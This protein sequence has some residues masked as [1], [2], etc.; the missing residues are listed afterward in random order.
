MDDNTSRPKVSV[1]VITYN[2][3]KYIREALDGILMQKVNFHY[4]VVIHDDASPDNTQNII[5]EYEKKYPDI[6]KVIY[7][8]ENKYSKGE[9]AFQYY[10][11]YLIGEYIAICEGDD[12]WTNPNKLQKQVDFLDKNPEYIAAA[13]N[14]RVINE[15]YEVINEDLHPY[16][17]FHE[18]I[19]KREDAFKLKLPSQLASI[20]YR[21]IWLNLDK[22]IIKLYNNCKTN[23]DQKLAVLLTNFGSIYCFKDVMA[24]HRKITSHGTSWSAR[25][26][27]KNT[28]L[29]MYKSLLE[30]KDFEDKAFGI[31]IENKKQRKDVYVAALY[32]FIK[33]PTGENK[34]AIKEINKI[35]QESYFE[36]FLYFIYRTICWPARV[37]HKIFKKLKLFC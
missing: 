35:K 15:N 1:L 22:K 26:Y 17:I 10:V 29:F 7:Q 14:V 33:K 3:G 34:N 20:V 18:Y 37:M 16:K 12:Y 27:G 2:H 19:F 8:A 23:G 21:N 6:I 4:E 11:D 25:I 31:K 5:R 28:S 30:V 36:L 32:K 24:D 13:H 9:S